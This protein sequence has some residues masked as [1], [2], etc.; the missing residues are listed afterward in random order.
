MASIPSIP[1][2][3]A[4]VLTVMATR[5]QDQELVARVAEEHGLKFNKESGIQDLEAQWEESSKILPCF[6]WHPWFSYQMYD[7]AQ[8]DERTS[9]DDE[10][11]IAHYTSVLTPSP[12]EE[13]KDFLLS[14][15]SPIPFN[16]FLSQTKR[17][18]ESYPL[19]LVGE[20]GLDKSFRLPHPEAERKTNEE[21]LTPGSREGRKLS[22]FR[23]DMA[24]QRYILRAQLN[25][26]GEMRRAVSVHGVAIHGV[27]FEALS[28]TWKDHE[29]QV[30]SK[31]EQRKLKAGGEPV[32]HAP[33]PVVEQKPKPYPP[34]I[35]LHSYS[36]PPEQVSQYLN[37]KIPSQ[38]FFSFSECINFSG[39]DPNPK[40]EEVIK[41]LPAD[42]ILVESDLHIAGE[43]MDG[44]LE[45]LVRR[46]CRLRGWG[47]EDGVRQLGK[48]WRVFA[49]G[50]AGG[51]Q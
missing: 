40:A 7:E 45:D 33:G 43:R 12:K 23:V 51:E 16:N 28:E 18:L 5:A 25:L 35:C 11:K 6:G 24:H 49:L 1:G 44:Y 31:R 32:S 9:L 22:S 29:L 3:K 39:P 19:A 4:K 36:G 14:L 48:N 41:M 27:L 26:A 38:I 46:V 20:I 42:R 34:R 50:V 8:F 37:P 13:D 47:L 15:P 2:M 17:Y 21:N 30:L 10:E